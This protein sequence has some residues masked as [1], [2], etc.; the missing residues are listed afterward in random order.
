MINNSNDYTFVE[1]VYKIVK[2][3][4]YLEDLCNVLECSLEEAIGILE[5]C[6]IYGKNV[7]LLKDNYPCETYKKD[8]NQIP[9]MDLVVIFL[10]FSSSLFSQYSKNN[11]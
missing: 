10:I 5:L 8:Y 9:I 7:E 3:G 4:M 6:K 11:L 1:K 2:N